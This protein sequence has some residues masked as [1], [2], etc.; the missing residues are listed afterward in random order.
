[1]TCEIKVQRVL[2]RAAALFFTLVLFD[3]TKV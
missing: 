1:M 3:T 2:L